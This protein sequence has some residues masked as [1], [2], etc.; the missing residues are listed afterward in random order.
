MTFVQKNCKMFLLRQRE[1]T[2]QTM[3]RK[4]S[5]ILPQSEVGVNKL[6]KRINRE[7]L[8]KLFSQLANQRF[9]SEAGGGANNRTPVRESPKRLPFFDC[10][11]RFESSEAINCFQ[12]AQFWTPRKRIPN[13]WRNVFTKGEGR[14]LLNLLHVWGKTNCGQSLE[15]FSKQITSFVLVSCFG[16]K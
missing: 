16:E 10:R 9:L 7:Q 12:F 5:S 3:C 6:D 2:T 14:S 8:L 1:I 13:V 4:I 15:T 11:A